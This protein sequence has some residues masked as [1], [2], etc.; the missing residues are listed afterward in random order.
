MPA[1][2]TI[3]RR[4]EKEKPFAGKKITMS[5]HMEAKTAYLATC[6]AAGGAEIHATGCNPLSTQDD[7]AAR[8]GFPGDP[9]LC[10]LWR[11]SRRVQKTAG[12]GPQLSS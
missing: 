10:S 9:N 5:I 8:P 1:L 3:R 2:G 7:V 11:Q 12:G 4:F 6:L